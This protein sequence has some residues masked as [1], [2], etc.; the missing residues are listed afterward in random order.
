MSKLNTGVFC[1]FWSLI[2][3]ISLIVKTILD[4]FFKRTLFFTVLHIFNC[5]F[6]YIDTAYK[7]VAKNGIFLL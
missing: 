2:N 3:Q 7:G 4:L 6:F 1:M 5:T